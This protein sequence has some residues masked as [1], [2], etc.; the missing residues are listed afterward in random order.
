MEIDIYILPLD[1]QY[2]ILQYVRLESGYKFDIDSIY[3]YSNPTIFFETNNLQINYSLWFGTQSPE[4][5][6]PGKILHTLKERSYKIEVERIFGKISKLIY[7]NLKK[8]NLKNDI[9]E[10]TSSKITFA[11]TYGPLKFNSFVENFHKLSF[12]HYTLSVENIN[13]YLKEMKIINNSYSHENYTQN[14]LDLYL[15]NLE[16]KI[17]E[18]VQNSINQFNNNSKNIIKKSKSIKNNLNFNRN[19]YKLCKPIPDEKKLIELS[20][21]KKIQKQ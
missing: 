3:F 7:L 4:N 17:S 8:F 9:L 6:S 10:E 19:F 13:D 12:V 5:F 16:K 1:I 21:I 14:S 2:I 20:F 15:Y 11:G 18:S